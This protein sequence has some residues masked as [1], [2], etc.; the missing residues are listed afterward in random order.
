MQNVPVRE[1]IRRFL[2]AAAVGDLPADYNYPNG[3]KSAPANNADILQMYSPDM[4]VQ[5]NVATGRG[6]PVEGRK[7]TWEQDGQEYW[8]IRCPKGAMDN[9][10]WQ[11][12][13][14]RWS[15]VEHAEA[16][17]MTGW[18]WANRRSRWVAFDFD[19]I[20]GHAP[21][22]GVTDERLQAIREAAFNLPYVQVRKSTRGGGYHLYVYFCDWQQDDD[23]GYWLGDGVECPNHTLHQALARCILSRMSQEANFCFA[24]AIDACGGNMWIWHRDA[25]KTNEGFTIVKDNTSLF[26]AEQ[27][28]TNW[29]DHVDV[30]TR[31]RTK[32]KIRGVPDSEDEDFDT[33]ASGRNV[34]P[35][36]EVHNQIIERLGEAGF[37]TI[38]VPEYNLLQTHTCAFARLMEEY[39]GEYVGFFDTLS[40][41][42]N[43][44]EPNCFAFPLSNGGW[45]VTR[46]SK[47][48]R[49]HDTWEQDGK[50]WTGCYF[51]T[52]PDLETAALAQGG[53]EISSNGGYQFDTLASAKRTAMALGADLGLP[54]SWDGRSTRLKRNSNGRLVVM[55]EKYKGEKSP[56][57][58]WIEKRDWWEKVFKVE[59]D[60]RDI[61]NSE[62]PEFDNFVRALVT[63]GGEHAGWAVKK[64]NKDG[65]DLQPTG[66]VKLMLMGHPF[67][68]PKTEAEVVMG[69]VLNRRWDLVN[70][71]FQPEF[72]GDRQW[73]FRAPQLRYVPQKLG[74]DEVPNHPFW[75]RV[76]DHIGYDLNEALEDHKWSTRYGIKTGRQ[77]LQLWIACM[78]REPFEPLP[79]LF[80]HGPENSGKSILHE[81]IGKLITGGIVYADKALMTT[82]DF[83]GELSNAVLA[84]VEE[85]DVA[86]AGD[87]ARNRMK[88]WVTSEFLS[89][90][91]MRTDAYLQKNTL[92]FIQA[93]N[94]EE[95]CLVQYGDTRT[96]MLHVRALLGD[97]IPKTVLKKNL[98]KEAPAFMTT[99]MEMDIPP[100]EGRL[101]IPYIT[102]ASKANM[103]HQSLNSLMRF[104]EENT[105]NINGA[106]IK[107]ADFFK[108]FQDWLSEDE[109]GYWTNRRVTRSL[110]T[111][112]YPTGQATGSGETH[113]GNIAWD[114]NEEESE[115]LV[116]SGRRLRTKS[117]ARER[118]S[119]KKD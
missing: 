92:H 38:W 17:G 6:T 39:P 25:N 96:T 69:G 13:T 23:G 53:A 22:V 29:Q 34:I 111:R 95:A 84:V 45:R 108:R 46:F 83:N 27:L 57:K 51:N 80:L 113:V 11:D 118:E 110:P 97:E 63:P 56:G 60:P 2:N 78:I 100:V 49:E 37:S 50:S 74:D 33:L 64:S 116:L 85:T 101:R 77:Y 16:I 8:H 12:Y 106:M 109:R 41:G 104:I 28:P 91:R 4:E 71:P 31:R 93:S 86:Q 54:D 89:I 59:T 70:M 24:S 30:V 36:D 61:Q 14:L 79:Y 5:V 7:N 35:L 10:N 47:G 94:S 73:N 65:W 72:P 98:E 115:Q 1:Q 103:E 19:A 99:I 18:D 9:P 102:T 114:T 105:Y 87:R 43:P 82:S 75:D 76:L 15:L 26:T 62:Y 20:T 68:V 40:V 112:I 81:A 58:G 52:R 55:V 117:E 44:G 67:N 90:R 88:D 32:I 21:G 3:P 48:I 119:N 107:F 66:N 42:D